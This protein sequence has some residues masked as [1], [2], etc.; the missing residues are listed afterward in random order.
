MPRVMKETI[1]CSLESIRQGMGNSGQTS[2]SATVWTDERHIWRQ[3]EYRKGM[4]LACY[5]LQ[6]IVI[7]CKLSRLLA[8]VAG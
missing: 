1:V 3:L 2:P 8:M 5:A 6:L 7:G 4:F